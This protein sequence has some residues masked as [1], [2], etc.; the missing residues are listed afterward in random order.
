MVVVAQ[1]D[2]TSMLSDNDE[3]APTTVLTRAAFKTNRVI[4]GH[5]LENTFHGVMDFKISHRFGYLNGGLYELFGIDN[6]S[7]RIGFDYGLTN[8]LQV[9]AGRSSYQKMYDAYAKYKLLWQS[10]GERDIP[11]SLLWVSAIAAS[12]TRWAN[13]DRDNLFVWRLYYT[14]QAI[15]GR[16]FSERFSAQVMPTIVHRNLVRTLD[17]SNTVWSLGTAARYKITNRIAVNAEY[18][19]VAPNQLSPGYRN[20]LSLGLDIETGGHVFQLHLTNATSMVEN[21]FITETVGNWSRGD[22][23]FGFNVSR[24]FTVVAPKLPTEL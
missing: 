19:W 22:I 14:H 7:V 4:N 1:P 18:F 5:S 8:R 3:N 23:H 13:P 11:I 15:V 10:T 2:G 24:V 20:A 21:A 6:A 16:K 17:E 12:T 9:G